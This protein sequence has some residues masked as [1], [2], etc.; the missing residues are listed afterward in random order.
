[1]NWD[2]SKS[3]EFDYG[4]RVWSQKLNSEYSLDNKL[5][6]RH[7]HGHRGKV[8]VHLTS[9]KLE[10]GMVT[11]FKHLNFFKKFLDDNVDHKFIFDINDPMI[12]TIFNKLCITA[13]DFKP[14]I[15]KRFLK[16]IEEGNFYIPQKLAA[17]KQEKINE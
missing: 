10:N 2:I 16:Y 12:P 7:L 13:D 5:A 14:V 1:M 4:H 8:I 17:Y 11:D 15:S 6:C 3:F 9:K